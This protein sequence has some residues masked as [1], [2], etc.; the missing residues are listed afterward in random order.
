MKTMSDVFITTYLVELT[1]LADLV[2][3]H[4]KERGVNLDAET[5]YDVIEDE[6]NLAYDN[7]NS[8]FCCRSEEEAQEK[9]DKDNT[10]FSL[11]ILEIAKM[12]GEGIVPESFTI[13]NEW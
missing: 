3:S 9:Y 13:H 5:I 4:A 2:A 1:K 12:A 8:S 7:H 11:I 10:A 6:Y